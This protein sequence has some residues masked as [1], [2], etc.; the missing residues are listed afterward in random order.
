MGSFS[1]YLIPKVYQETIPYRVIFVDTETKDEVVNENTS[2]LRLLLGCYEVW[3]V[4][5]KGI[6]IAMESSGV[7]TTEYEFYTLIKKHKPCRVVAHNWRFDATVL[8][9]GARDNLTRYGY[10]IDIGNSIIPVEAKGFT[11]FLV[12]LN[13]DGVLVELICNTNFY[14]QSLASLGA[15][16]DADKYD[17]PSETDYVSYQDYLDDLI[18]YCARDVE[19]LRKSYFFLFEFTDEIGGVTPASTIAMSANRVYRNRFMS[20]GERIQGTLGI[21]YISDIEQE[22]YKGGRTDAFFRGNPDKQIYKYDVNSLYPYSML[23][24]IPVR[25]VQAAPQNMLIDA[26]ESDDS[27]FIYLADVTISIHEDDKHSFI[28]GEGVK[29]D[30]GELIFPI[31]EYRCWVWQPMIE[32]LYTR[33]YIKEIHKVYAYNKSPLFNDYVLTL[34][35]LR[36][37]YKKSGDSARDLLVKILLN[38]LYGKFG[39]REH[40]TWD[41]ADEYETVVMEREGVGIDRFGEIYEDEFVE[42]LQIADTLYRS[43]PQTESN[44]SVNSVMSI[45][46]YITTNARSILWE[47]LAYILDMRGDVYY[48]D[49]DSIFTSIQLPE[50]M[51]S[52]TELGKWK[53]EE[54]IPKGEADFIAPK[55]YRVM[56]K[57]TIKGIR[58][59]TGNDEHAQKIFP[60]F[61]TDLTSKNKLR[62]ARL[63]SGAVITRIVKRPT[64]NNNKRIYAGENSPTYPLILN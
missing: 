43:I 29:T 17:M 30:K 63:D 16:F 22:A 62:K 45:A 59:P 4:D 21:P 11:P 56:D 60:N 47:T 54:I 49:T 14:K 61:I 50:H 8:R 40:S 5:A 12:S 10:D 24:D 19:V 55:H 18:A 13:F 44:P 35:A 2:N 48:C 23:G 46:G 41:I 20:L 32:T 28:G 37:E 15:S 25:Y 34:Y 51:V 42:Y 53:L 57:W 27:R 39:Q 26:L 3:V 6:S 31:G 38:S 58:N 36:E 52:Q 1:R 64:G 7:F 33:N 9:V